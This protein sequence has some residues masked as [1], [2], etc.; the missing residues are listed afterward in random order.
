MDARQLRRVGAVFILREPEF[1]GF[2]I[3]AEHGVFSLCEIADMC[4]IAQA[5]GTSAQER[6]VHDRHD[7]D[8]SGR[9]PGRRNYATEG[10]HAL[11]MGPMGLSLELGLPDQVRHER[12]N[13]AHMTGAGG[14]YISEQNALG[15]RIVMGGND[16]AYLLQSLTQAAEAMDKAIKGQG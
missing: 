5:C 14:P 1:D 16:T 13:Q 10:F 9:G 8:R 7:R 15:A 4:L 6:G 2:Y 11:M 12:F 3:D